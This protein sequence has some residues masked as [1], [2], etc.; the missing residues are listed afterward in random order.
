MPPLLKTERLILRAPET[1]DLEAIYRLGRNPRVMRFI[2]GTMQ[3]L[4]DARREL[5]RR[6]AT[7]KEPLGYW[8]AEEKN[9][10]DFVGWMGL[11]FLEDSGDIE[12]GYRFMEEHW[13]K[14]YATEGGAKVLDYAFI[15]LNLEK[16]VAVAM[17]ENRAS[18]RVM[19]KLGMTMVDRG[20]YYGTECVYYRVWRED[21]LNLSRSRGQQER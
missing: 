1:G 12:I 15:T 19:E 13:G 9:S 6:I 20:H 21:Y 17:E 5:T 14:G 2:A 10:G 8:V 7:A 16:V 18:T 4:E 3:S 11:K